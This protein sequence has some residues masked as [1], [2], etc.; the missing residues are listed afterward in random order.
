MSLAD[1][2]VG[3]EPLLAPILELQ[4][5]SKPT[6]AEVL[7]RVQAG[8]LP[9][10]IAFCEDT[11]HRKLGLVCGFGAGKTYALICK[12]LHMAA[13]NVGHVSALFEPIAPMLRDILM[14]Q[15]DELLTKFEIPFD[16]RVSPLP[17]Y[18]IHFKEGSHTI[19]LRT[20]E[21]ANRIRGLNLCSV[22][23]D[24][25]D[26]ANKSV[27]TQAMRMALARLR[28]GNVQQFYAATTPEGFGWAYDTF[29][30]NAGDDTAL[31]RA[32]TSDNPFLPEGFIDSLLQNYPEQLIQSYLN[33]VFVNLN[34]GQV[35][36][37]FDRAKHVIETAPVNLDNEPRHWGCDFNIGNCRA[38][39]GVR[40]G[41]QFLLIDELKAHDT[42][43]MAAE[44]KRRSAHVSAPVYVYPDSSGANRHS[45]AAKT[46]VELLRMAGLSVVA[47]RSNPLIKDRVAAVQ[48]LLLNGK[49]IVRLQILAKCEKMIECLELQGYSQRNPESP[50]KEGGYDHL[51]D[52]LGYVVWALYNPLHVRAGRGTGIRVY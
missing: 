33:G 9:H 1:D 8:L 40:L 13:L 29:E 6:T 3:N 4:R 49:G 31:I 38:I 35:Y 48:A 2:V 37:R 11:E 24:E 26:T 34:T 30:K 51:T 21:T 14:R 16:F 44:I 32:K 10:Q 23:F 17:E 52:S 36:D 41:Q 15:M 42:D 7:Q 25:A 5:F 47:G 19:M 39:C 12:S 45:S 43:A 22:G 20:M 27:A 28:S 50:C 46:D 18:R